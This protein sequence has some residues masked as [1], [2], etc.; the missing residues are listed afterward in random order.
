M[1]MLAGLAGGTFIWRKKKWK[2]REEGRRGSERGGGGR[3]E[4]GG[5]VVE[6]AQYSTLIT[7]LSRL[8]HQR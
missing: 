8:Q 1:V 4:R 7:V 6:E 5:A 2:G 3:G